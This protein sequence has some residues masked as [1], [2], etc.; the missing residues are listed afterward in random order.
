M[1]Q[2]ADNQIQVTEVLGSMLTGLTFY[3]WNF[4]FHTVKP[5]PPLLPISANLWK[6]RVVRPATK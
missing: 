3:C 5:V 4:C 2:T 6:T 1:A